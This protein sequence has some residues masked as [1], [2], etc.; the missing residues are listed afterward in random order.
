MIYRVTGSALIFLAN[1]LLGAST[2]YSNELE[3]EGGYRVSIPEGVEVEVQTPVEDFILYNFRVQNETS[4]LTLY[5]GN[6]PNGYSE[7]P[8]G[9]EG[10]CIIEPLTDFSSICPEMLDNQ[11][12]SVKNI[13]IHLKTDSWPQFAHFFYTEKDLKKVA[14]VKH[15]ISSYKKNRE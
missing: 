15:I 5:I 12:T 4:F 6:Q 1:W 3:I 9:N 11:D 14:Y 10:T 13:Y 7:N 2:V 8:Q